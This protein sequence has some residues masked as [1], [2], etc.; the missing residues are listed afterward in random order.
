MTYEDAHKYIPM[1]S[2]E[3]PPDSPLTR[4]TSVY[5][6]AFRGRWQIT[7]MGPPGAAPVEYKGCLFVL[8]TATEGNFIA[9]GDTPCPGQQ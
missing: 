7:P 4:Q 1:L 5:L 9:G 8:F 6:V 3:Y 2:S